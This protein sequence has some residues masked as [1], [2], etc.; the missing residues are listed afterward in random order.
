MNIKSSAGRIGLLSAMVVFLPACTVMTPV[1]QSLAG[2]GGAA[3]ETRIVKDSGS[4]QDRN[5]L[6]Y[7]DV[8][9]LSAYSDEWD[10]SK[11]AGKDFA[12]SYTR[13]VIRSEVLANATRDASD[14]LTQA[15]GARPLAYKSRP[16]PVRALVGKEF[17]ANFSAA[18]KVGSFDQV[19][20]LLTIGHQSNSSGEKW[21]R[22]VY[23][24]ALD[25]PLFLVK[26]DGSASVPQIHFQVKVDNT[27]ASRGAAAALGVAVQIAK[28]LANPPLVMTRLTADSAKNE[29][30]AL[31]SA[32]SQLF[33]NSITE[34]HWTDRDLRLWRPKDAT[35][36]VP[37][38]VLVRFSLPENE[39]DYAN[40]VRVGNWRITF[41]NPRP[42]IFADWRVC[43]SAVQPRCAVDM[44]TA[45]N[46]VVKE[47]TM[48]EILNYRL[49]PSNP[50]ISSIETYLGSRSWYKTSLVALSTKTGAERQAAL[51]SFCNSVINEVT[52]LDLSA[53]DAQAVLWALSK[54]TPDAVPN[55]NQAPGCTSALGPFRNKS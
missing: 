12:G 1:Y 23:H 34:E 46:E 20:P 47:V 30:K 35:S 42:S 37:S 50:D 13:L 40:A 26:R 3:P 11:G 17:S 38:G 8:T 22:K 31:D 15:P 43:G 18:V 45:K 6:A 24:D 28:A 36:T 41:E 39:D 29:A 27:Y 44:E 9:P 49:V 48:G 4:A 21:T 32:I 54:G 51:N 52:R 33:S 25:F 53:F 2:P 14:N 7:L 55:M 5:K 10:E 16:W 19:V